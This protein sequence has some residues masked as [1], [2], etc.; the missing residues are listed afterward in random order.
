M[1]YFVTIGERALVVDLDGDRVLV[2][3]VPV[4]AEFERVPGTPEIRLVLDGRSSLLAVEGGAEGAWHLVDRGALR[5]VRVEDERSRHIRLLAGEGKSQ[6]GGGVLKS[7]M[8]GLVVKVE[9][10]VGDLVGVGTG[11]VVLEAMKME[12]EL[13]AT[14]PGV[15]TAIR[16]T[17][18]QAVE[19]GQVLI[20]TG[21]P[22]EG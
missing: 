10:A 18:G 5:E 13:K 21:P 8:P 12:N 11:L 1:K 6:G 4:R 20:E 19:R 22:A 3:G 17:A 14:A 7:P 2:D 9:V 16:V 15:V